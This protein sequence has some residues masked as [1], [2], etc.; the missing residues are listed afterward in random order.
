[1]KPA[2]GFIRAILNF[3]EESGGTHGI[4]AKKIDILKGG[5]KRISSTTSDLQLMKA[6]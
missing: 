4:A 6:F 1:M 5:S 3:A 2:H